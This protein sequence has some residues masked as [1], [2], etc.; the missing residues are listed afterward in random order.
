[1]ERSFLGVP[2][3]AERPGIM[4]S[5]HRG[6]SIPLAQPVPEIPDSLYVVYAFKRRF[7]PV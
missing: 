6:V 2:E 7:L 3:A 1:M 5:G 4:M